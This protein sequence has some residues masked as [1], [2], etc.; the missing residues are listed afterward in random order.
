M[1]DEELI[2]EVKKNEILYNKSSKLFKD[3]R[4]KQDVW[5]EI[6]E[7]LKYTGKHVCLTFNKSLFNGSG[8]ADVLLLLVL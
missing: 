1:D 6:G 7:K 5:K 4:K 8:D 2:L 3:S